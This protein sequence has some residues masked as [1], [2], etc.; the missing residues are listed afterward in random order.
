MGK[1]ALMIVLGLSV[2]VGIIGYTINRSKSQLVVN[3]AGFDKYT[4]A[5]N[6]AQTSVNMML[7]RMDS[8]DRSILDSIVPG[9]I[10]RMVTNVMGGRC[11]LTI[12]LANPAYLDTV[13]L[14]AHARFMDST[15]YMK[16]RL[17]RR[18]VP[19]PL[20]NAAVGLRIPDVDQFLMSG[21]PFIDG[22]NH[23]ANGNLIVP[24]DTSSRAGVAVL[25]PTDTT[26][27]LAYASKIDGTKD[28]VIDSSM[29]NP[30]AFVAEYIS[31]ADTMFTSGTYGS[32]MTWGTRTIPWIVYA[33]GNVTFNG[34]IE[35]WGILVV[36]GN[37]TLAGTFMFHGLVIAYNDISI[38]VTFAKGTP[39][40][41][42]GLLMSGSAGSDFGMKG[43]SGIVFSREAL[44]IAKYVSK[45]Q[46][47]RVV[48]WYE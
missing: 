10:A 39:D 2:A 30:A 18:P 44:E 4:M 32:N 29:P 21:T 28:V 22:R 35:G 25:N 45:L 1:M 13:D 33:D 7:R 43:N 26:Q 19:F 15:R 36:R 9:G 40:I 20:V 31:A 37:L 46:E 23:D 16:L 8:K 6:I 34:N 27:V 24:T 48:W 14:T 5:R 3:V 47:Y 38:D 41:V 11:S 42:G 17:R 12:K